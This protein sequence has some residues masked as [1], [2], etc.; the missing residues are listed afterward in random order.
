MLPWLVG[1]AVVAVGAAV[2]S[3]DDECKYCSDRVYKNGLCRY[4]YEEELEEIR[5]EKEEEARRREK[6]RQ[7][8]SIRREIRE[9]ERISIE[10]FKDKYGIILNINGKHITYSEEKGE[11]RKLQDRIEEL[12]EENLI[13]EKILEELKKELD[14]AKSL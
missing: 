4:H 9:F 14:E 2:L 5:R 7:K 6:E 3:S 12:R 8:D 1:A 10:N 11:I 13:I